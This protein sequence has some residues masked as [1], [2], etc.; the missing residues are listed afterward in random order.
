MIWVSEVPR[1]RDHSSF[2]MNAITLGAPAQAHAQKVS[3]LIDIWGL[4]FSMLSLPS[5]CACLV[6]YVSL[7][8]HKGGARVTAYNVLCPC[9]GIKPLQR[10][11]HR[12]EHQYRYSGTCASWWRAGED[13]WRVY[14]SF[15]MTR[16]GFLTKN[17][18]KTKEHQPHLIGAEAIK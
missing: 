9:L 13:V 14:F 12:R 2:N 18:S 16:Q 8:I 15:Q 6:I 5:V 11:N 1:S 4:F 17:I 7:T 10:W 3:F